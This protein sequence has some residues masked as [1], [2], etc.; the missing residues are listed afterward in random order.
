MDPWFPMG[1]ADPVQV[2]FAGALGAQLTAPAEI[3]ECHRMITDRAAAV[4]GL[5]EAYG[6]VEGR[7]ASFVV[8][9]ALDGIDVLRR[10]VRPR[11]VIARGHLLAEGPAAESVVYWPGEEARTVDFVRDGDRRRS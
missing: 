9:P 1:M 7:P 3:A 2:A 4:L 8:L 11:Y 5:D 6:L 10:H